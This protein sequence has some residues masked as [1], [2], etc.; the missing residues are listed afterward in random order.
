MGEENDT[1]ARIRT[2][3]RPARSELLSRLCYPGSP[4]AKVRSDTSC[5]KVFSKLE[6]EKLAHIAAKQGSIIKI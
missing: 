4:H 2:P 3:D 1:F 6:L 5:L